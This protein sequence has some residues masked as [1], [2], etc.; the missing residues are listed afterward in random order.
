MTEAIK[1][2]LALFIF[3]APIAAVLT[4]RSSGE[5]MLF[6]LLFLGVLSAIWV[7]GYL[8]ERI[9]ARKLVGRCAPFAGPRRF[10][11]ATAIASAKAR[12]VVS[13]A[14]DG[15]SSWRGD[16]SGQSSIR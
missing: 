16:R 2:A 4:W 3:C 11:C 15:V 13:Y 14:N 9:A 12:T 5:G 10:S 6:V 7:L 8:S 1:N